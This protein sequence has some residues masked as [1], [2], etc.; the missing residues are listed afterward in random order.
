MTTKQQFPKFEIKPTDVAEKIRF[1]LKEVKQAYEDLKKIEKPTIKS[2]TAI[3]KVEYPF[4]LFM[5]ELSHIMGVAD[6][7]NLFMDVYQ[8]MIPELSLHGSSIGQDIELYN[9]FKEILKTEMTEI[10][11]RVLNREM[12][13]FK[14]SGIDLPKEDQVRLTEI[15]QRL[16]E[17]SSTF[18][19]NIVKDS[20]TMFVDLVD[21]LRLEG[22][23]ETDKS[24]FAMQAAEIEGVAYRIKTNS[25][26]YLAVVYYSEDE[27][28]RK[29]CYLN[30]NT[31][32]TVR[33]D[34]KEFDNTPLM[35]ETLDLRQEK[36]MLLGYEN[37]AEYSLSNKMAESPE[38]V[39]DFLEDLTAKAAPQY[40]EE[41]EALKDYAFE[42]GYIKNKED[43]L[44]PWN[45]SRMSRIMK[46][47]KFSIDEE[48][49]R[50]YFPMKKVQE[51][52]FWTIKELFGY[53][54][55]Q[56]DFKFNKYVD[57]LQLFEIS[58]DGVLTAYIYGD[59]FAYDGKRGGAWMS[60][61][62]ERTKD[63][64]PV[65]FVTC[66]FPQPLKG[67]EALLSFDEV[68]T[69]FH[70]FGHALH[71]TLTKVT[72]SGA[73]GISGV[74][75]DAVELPSTFMEFFCVKEEVL[76]KISGHFETGETLPKET[77]KSLIDS[78]HFCSAMGLMR[79]M[80]FSLS[81]M[82]AHA[83]K[84]NDVNQVSLEFI[85]KHGLTKPYKGTAF[86]NKFGHIFAGGYAA[87]YYSYKWADI[88]ASDI[89]ETF[90]EN[91]VICRETGEHYLNSILSQGS[92]KEIA[93]MFRDFK[94]RDPKPEPF[95]KYTG[96]KVS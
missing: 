24:R 85:E 93:D 68:V 13:G 81:D 29:E 27:E 82:L 88:L 51:G 94:G 58:K 8:E 83:H 11:K 49:I 91:G 62:T 47:D 48:K 78:E 18:S 42:N 71:H 39:I 61:Y 56:V 10:E 67:K 44:K 90:E 41:L 46:E 60:D 66:N 3:D 22:L 15:N 57:E 50:E 69:T 12:I 30:N 96:I 79:Q 54:V 65:A 95:L 63:V 28:L 43:K 7:D 6:K 40:K 55:K 84:R 31:V 70:E 25:P 33:G 37:Y 80:E 92:S 72:T 38:Q 1:H 74:P 76:S 35:K 36:S 2:L 73:E 52:L 32:A 89:F 9:I 77:V 5:S 53:D 59:F 64:V 14:H 20:E 21:D 86:Y 4:N 87:G 23:P 45:V 75:W 17:L 19:T 16:S 34:H 26:D